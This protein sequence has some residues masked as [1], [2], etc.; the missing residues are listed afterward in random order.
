MTMFAGLKMRAAGRQAPVQF[1]TRALLTSVALAI[2]AG[3]ALAQDATWLPNPGPVDDFNTG[4]NWSSGNVPTGTA[5]FD[6]STVTDLTFSTL[7][8]EIGGWIFEGTQDYTFVSSASTVR[9]TGAGI[10]VNGGS[11]TIRPA[12]LHFDNNSTA[13]SAFIEMNA[14]G[15]G[16]NDNSSAA[17]FTITVN[18]HWSGTSGEWTGSGTL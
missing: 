17:D 12:D 6:T 15:L 2:L 14:G 16:F 13:G 11:A 8:M 10:V 5:T 3:T 9:F 18:N 7:E 1:R 4:T